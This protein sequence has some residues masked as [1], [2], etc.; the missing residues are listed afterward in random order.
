[1]PPM[2][3]GLIVTKSGFVRGFLK[4]LAGGLLILG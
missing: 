1:M 3:D 4:K 2:A